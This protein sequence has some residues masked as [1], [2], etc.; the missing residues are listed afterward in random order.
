VAISLVGAN[1]EVSGYKDS[2]SATSGS[3]TTIGD[4]SKSWT[5]NQF[6]PA[7]GTNYIVWITGGAGAGGSAHITG[8]SSISLTCADGF[9]KPNLSTGVI[10]TVVPDATSTYAILYNL[11]DCIAAVPANCSWHDATNKRTMVCNKNILIKANS[12][13]GMYGT[14]TLFTADGA[15]YESDSASALCQMGR[16]NNANA[17]VEGATVFTPRNTTAWYQLVFLGSIRWYDSEIKCNEVI[18]GTSGMRY[19]DPTAPAEFTWINS[20]TTFCSIA[21]YPN[22]FYKDSEAIKSSMYGIGAPALL[23]GIVYNEGNQTVSAAGWDGAHSF[24]AHFTGDPDS[25]S[26][27]WNRPIVYY[28]ST[29]AHSVGY[30]WNPRFDSYSALSDVIDWYTVGPHTGV[31]YIGTTLDI[32]TKKAS[33]GSALGAA[34]VGV[35]KKSDGVGQ[36]TTA[37]GATTP[38]APTK[39]RFIT[40][41]GSGE[42]AGPSFAPTRGICVASAKLT[43]ASRN[44]STVV[45]YSGYTLIL[46]KYGYVQAV[47]DRNYPYNQA[48]SEIAYSGITMTV[49]S[50]TQVTIN[51]TGTRT[52]QE[53]YDFVKARLD[54]EAKTNDVHVVD[55]FTTS[56][57]INYTLNGGSTISVTGS[58]SDETK[59]ITGTVN[60]SSG[61]FYENMAGVIWEAGGST[62]YASHFY[63]NVKDA[64]TASTITTGVVIAYLD[65]SGNDRTYNTSLV[66]GGLTTDG[67]GNIDGYVVYK[68]DAAE[69]ND[70]TAY[71]GEYDYDW[72]S[73]PKT[74]SGAPVGSSGSREVLR[75]SPDDTVVLS[76]AA[77][78]A[79][80]GVTVDHT[81]KICDM[82]LETLTDVRDNLKARQARTN[83]IEAGT[84]GYMSFYTLG[85]YSDTGLFL[86]YDGTVYHG[87]WGWTY[88]NSGG[89]G[90]LKEKD[91][92]GIA[93]TQTSWTLNGTVVGQAVEVFN[94]DGAAEPAW[95]A[96]TAKTVGN[97]V[98]RSVQAVSITSAAGVATVTEVGHPYTTGDW[99]IIA[100]AT[101]TEYNTTAKVTKT[102]ANTYT[103]PI[104]GTP[105]SPATGSPTAQDEMWWFECSVGGTTGGAEPTWDTTEGNTTADNSVTWVCRLIEVVNDTASGASYAFTYE[106]KGTDRSLRVRNRYVSGTS[107]NMEDVFTDTATE[108]GLTRDVTLEANASYEDSA[109]DGSLVTECSIIGS[110]LLI[111]VDDPDNQTTWQR[112]YNWY[113]YYLTTADGMRSHAD[114]ITAISVVRFTL[115]GVKIINQDTVNPLAIGGGDA[116]PLTGDPWDILDVSNGAS[117]IANAHIV[118]EFVHSTGSGLSAA[119]NTKLMGLPQADENA[120]ELLDR[121]NTLH[122]DAGSVGKNIS[123]G[124]SGGGGGGDQL[125]LPLFV[126]LK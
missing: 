59:V 115:D 88:Q 35:I 83:D 62:Y 75:L 117:I 9:Q 86:R 13:L 55:P 69:D 6:K 4:T 90:T 91:A 76:K 60:I 67:S 92:S 125:T 119:Q 122:V 68:I 2:G 66:N 37:V 33:D 73:I 49:I 44:V 97:G 113:Q 22:S 118:E 45:D 58:L 126:A 124:A 80:S 8:N 34:A 104:N 74:I 106:H 77:A 14:N 84:P 71:C 1:V 32:S 15:G 20:K 103:Y 23:D 64:V 89:G 70:L 82:S 121:D 43:R 79:V 100:G 65:S 85:T 63:H 110:L 98:R 7:T 102:G 42:Y 11:A 108:N 12:G 87:A 26:W 94:V 61:G 51:V 95:A 16:L 123:D 10:D 52:I 31:C 101:Q 18:G 96:T 48:N 5:A 112:V 21:C 25:P 56:D 116:L 111:F 57:G 28:A 99:V 29:I 39:A 17:G 46:T 109:V 105:A 27:L 24:N 120:T 53:A 81:T 93:T 19:Y 72:L 30:F 47:N 114:N 41:D 50:P 36:I 38:F 3:A 54:Y 78:L 40:T 107:A